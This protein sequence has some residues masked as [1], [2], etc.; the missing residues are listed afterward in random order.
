MSH[1]VEGN[2]ME[3]MGA[4]MLQV[5]QSRWLVHLQALWLPRGGGG[6]LLWWSGEMLHHQ[7]GPPAATLGRG[8][9]V[10][11]STVG[12]QERWGKGQG[13]PKVRGHDNNTPNYITAQKHLRC[14]VQMAP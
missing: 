4:T 11:L 6:E 9:P 8:A 3:G 10:V 7:T 12:G 13:S 5:A 1:I 2:V 14:A